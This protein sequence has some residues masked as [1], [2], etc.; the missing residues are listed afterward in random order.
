[1]SRLQRVLFDYNAEVEEEV[2]KLIERCGLPLWD[3][4]IAAQ[5][6]VHDR[7]SF[8]AKYEQQLRS[9]RILG[10]L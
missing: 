9:H 7:R 8:Q 10:V 1:M 6:I 5:R 3:A 2:A 4:I